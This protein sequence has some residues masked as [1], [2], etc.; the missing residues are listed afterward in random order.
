RTGAQGSRGRRRLW[1]RLLL[2]RASRH[3]RRDGG[4]RV[5]RNQCGARTD[6]APNYSCPSVRD[7]RGIQGCRMQVKLKLAIAAA[8]VLTA[9]N[10][11]LIAWSKVLNDDSMEHERKAQETLSEA[12]KPYAEARS[13]AA[14]A[15]ELAIRTTTISDNGRRE[16]EKASVVMSQMRR[17]L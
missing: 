3:A 10:P 2:P 14:D 8:I 17:A 4:L 5:Q 13:V 12:N 15:T 1:R 9:A 6:A 16:I 7:T 11:G